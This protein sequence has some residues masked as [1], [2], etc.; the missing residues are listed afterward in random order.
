MSVLKVSW[1]ALKL[2]K[3]NNP[4]DDI[5]YSVEDEKISNDPEIP[6]TKRYFLEITVQGAVYQCFVAKVATPEAGSDQKDFEDN[7]KASAI[8]TT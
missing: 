6:D 5:Y 1:S 4:T 2:T 3:I 7:Y 8:E